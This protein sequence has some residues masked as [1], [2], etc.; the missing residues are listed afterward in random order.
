MHLHD[1]CARLTHSSVN[2][3]ARLEVRDSLALLIAAAYHSTVVVHLPEKQEVVGLNPTGRA[4]FFLYFSSSPCDLFTL[5]H[6][7][8]LP[9]VRLVA[10]RTELLI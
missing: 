4:E 2:V 7:F 3:L 5:H 6:S 9:G 1:T 10:R 8:S